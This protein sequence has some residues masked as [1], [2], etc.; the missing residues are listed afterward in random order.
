MLYVSFLEMFPKAQEYLS[1]SFGEYTGIW[2][3]TAAFFFGMALIMLIDNFIPSPE[4]DLTAQKTGQHSA[5]I[6]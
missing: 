3:V 5:I 1:K 4:S 2:W 6:K